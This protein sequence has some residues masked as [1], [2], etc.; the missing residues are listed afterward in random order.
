MGCVFS[1]AL[2]PK[3]NVFC[4]F[5]TLYFNPT[6]LSSSLVPLRGKIDI[7]AHRLF[8][9]NS[10]PNN[11]Y[12]KLF[13]MG[14]VFLAA[15]SSKQNVFCC[16]STLYFNHINLSSPMAPL[17]GEIDICARKLLYTKFNSQQLLSEAFFHGMRIFGVSVL[18][19]MLTAMTSLYITPCESS[20]PIFL[21]TLS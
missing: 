14:C 20:P 15:L 4:C 13:F 21:Y 9:R 6:H 8:I 17:R 10:M 11:F 16:F 7:C 2:S 5:S 19:A 12:L 1:A 3:Q 18:Q